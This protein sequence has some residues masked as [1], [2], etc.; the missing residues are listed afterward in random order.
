MENKNKIIITMAILAVAVVI[1][2]VL[3]TVMNKS[4][5]EEASNLIVPQ[6]NLINEASQVNPDMPEYFDVDKI[7]ES[8]IIENENMSES[9][10]SI[11]ESP[12]F[13]IPKDVSGIEMMTVEEKLSMGIDENLNVQILGRN[14]AG[15]VTGYQ[16]IYNEEDFVIDLR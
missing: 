14:E 16:F 4:N 12:D 11:L 10:I 6:E 1:T 13:S 7:I 9:Q 2:A 3:L 5:N 8:Q 15:Q